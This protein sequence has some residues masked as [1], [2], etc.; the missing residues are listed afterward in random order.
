MDR[1]VSNHFD[2]KYRSTSSAGFSAKKVT[3]A[4]GR[5]LRLGVWDTAGDPAFT[6][7]TR[8]Y[9]KGVHAA[10]VC[11]SLQHPPSYHRAKA[12]TAQL[13][14]ATNQSAKVYL[15]VLRCDLLCAE[16]R[17]CVRQALADAVDDTN[18]I[19]TCGHTGSKKHE[20]HG[21]GLVDP[22]FRIHELIHVFHTHTPQVCIAWIQM[23]TQLESPV[24]MHHLAPW[25]WLSM[26]ATS[27]PTP[28][29]SRRPCV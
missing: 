27:L 2:G 11:V 29:S 26:R 16:E 8:A 15:A 7:L 9:L 24:T 19:G 18:I 25:T 10:I 17:G 23:L 12:W 20:E 14:E 22:Y 6:A 21:K 1:F 13:L 4:D 5:V 28:P 3:I